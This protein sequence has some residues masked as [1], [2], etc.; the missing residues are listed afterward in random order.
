ML[1]AASVVK[2]RFSPEIDSNFP[3]ILVT[4]IFP[5]SFPTVLYALT[6]LIYSLTGGDPFLAPHLF[7]LPQFI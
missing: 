5:N 6:K 2:N 3:G 1:Y 7:K 4:L